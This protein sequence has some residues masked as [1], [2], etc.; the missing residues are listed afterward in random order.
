MKKDITEL[1]VALDDFCNEYASF[2]QKQYLPQNHKPTR[3]PCL[4]SSEI[5]T[6]VLLFHRSPAEN[7]KFF[8]TSYLQLYKSKFP[9]LPSY[10]RFVELQQRYLGHFHALIV[11]LSATAKHTGL[12]Y[13]DSTN[14]PVCHRKRSRRHRVF[15]GLAT[16]LNMSVYLRP[17]F[18][19]IYFLKRNSG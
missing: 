5:M 1:F 19:F 3:I 10:N 13:V 15:K 8:Y 7:F 14:I 9:T 17:S 4:R 2:L 16:F 6:I 11:I 18:L 12:N